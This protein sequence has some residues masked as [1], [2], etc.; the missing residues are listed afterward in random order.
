MTIVLDWDQ[1]GM[2][3]DRVEVGSE[4]MERLETQ[5]L[6]NEAKLFVALVHLSSAKVVNYIPS[7]KP[8]YHIHDI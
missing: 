8:L 4:V 1:I 6:G 3:V 2:N 5:T 7:I